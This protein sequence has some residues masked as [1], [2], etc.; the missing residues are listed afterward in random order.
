MAK[1]RRVLKKLLSMGWV[2]ERRKGSHR[3]LK[4][5]S[6]ILLFTYHDSDDLGPPAL[7]KVAKDV[8]CKPQDLI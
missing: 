3:I 2:E 7:A 8:G 1:A 4:K 6:K 5:D